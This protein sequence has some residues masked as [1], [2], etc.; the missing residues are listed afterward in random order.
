M[1]V[2]QIGTLT[3]TL[4]AVDL[5]HRH[6]YRCMM[7]HR[8]GETEDTT[9][10]DLAVAANCGQIKTGA[11]ARCERVAKYN[12]LLRIEE[13]LDDAARYAGAGAFPRFH[14]RRPDPSDDE[15]DQPTVPPRDR[16][17]ATGGRAAA[18]T[19]RALVLGGGA[20][21]CSS[22]CWPSPVQRYLD[23]P[24]RGE[25]RRAAAARRP[26]ELA[27]AAQQQARVERPGLHRSSRPATRLQYADARRH[28]VRRRVDR[29]AKPATAADPPATAPPRR[30]RRR[31]WNDRLWASVHA[32]ARR[33][34]VRE[35]G[36]SRARGR[37]PAVV[38][39]Q[40]GRPPRAMRA[41]AHRCPCGQP[42]RRRDLAAVAR[43][44]PVPDAVLPHLPAGERGDR[45]PGGRR[46]D[47][48]R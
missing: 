12:Q 22:W 8:S 41:V 2:N 17:A 9:I 10:A 42:G 33:T 32:A 24:Q 40:L 34:E 14:G 1:K 13:E 44:H 23:Q 36:R 48:A 30:G 5:A 11:P 35:P 19:G 3:E 7:S 4:D 38:A 29:G 45:P 20:S 47:G 6:G 31:R 46:A 39:A 18:S 43:R 26:A 16:R 27:A 28:R 37:R 15:S 25:Q 21:S